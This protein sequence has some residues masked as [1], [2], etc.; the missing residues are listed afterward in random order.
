MKFITIFALLCAFGG[1][2]ANAAGSGKEHP[3][4]KVIN[5][6]EGLKAK[7]IAQGKDEEVAYTK[8]QYWCSTSIAE[9]KDAI[10]DEKEKIEELEDQL[11]GLN[12][13]KESLE[14]EIQT[15]EDQIGELEAAAKEAKE[16]RAAEAKLYDKANK[17]LESTIKAMDQCIAALKG[18]ESKTEAM[19]AQKHVRMVL[20][21]ISLKVTNS[22]R[23]VLEDFA[24]KPRPDQLAAG[25]L[26]AHVDKYDFKS[27]NVIELLK[28]LKLKFE[29]D[30]L[31]GT[32]AETN[33]VN[34]YE[35]AKEAR[36]NAIDAAKKA[37]G[38][39]E[40]KLASVEKDIAQAEKELKSTQDDLKADS[41]SLKETEEACNTK[42]EEWETRSETRTLELEAMDQ[43]IK[44]LAKSAGVRTEA[45]GNPIPPP[46]PVS[47]L[48]LSKDQTNDPKM[49]AVALL[50][51]A[52][53]DTHSRALERLA[54][55]V[56][57]HLSGPF[58]Q[59]NN[60][61]EKMIF[62]LMDEQKQEDEHKLW[63]DQ[64]IEKTETMKED[65]EEKIKDLKAE[66]KVET[67]AV[68]TLTEEIGEAEKMI[69]D[70]VAFMAEATEIRETGKKENALAIKD[71]KDA[72]KSVTNAI[73]VLEAFYKESGEIPKEPWEFIQKP[74]NLGKKPSTWDAGYTGVADPDQKNAGIISILEAVLSDFEKMEAETKSN[75]AQDQ[76]EYDKSMSANNIEKSGREQEVS[77]KTAE[78]KRRNDK[79]VSLNGQKKDTEAELEK[80]EQYLVDLKPAC[81]DGDSSYDDRKAA[82]A[83]E[84]EALKKA[85]VILEDAF[86]EKS[87]FLQ[88]RRH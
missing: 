68:Q 39:K 59:V 70:I 55:A 10:A 52:A 48:Q 40:K 76:E 21:L 33:S 22:Q 7:A 75:E 38:K 51:E 28:Q 35:V 49:K 69:S 61:I 4:A 42:K 58:D 2:S 3:I 5:L 65:K 43:A 17:D 80:T 56:A 13:E 46:S 23:K 84:I 37:K 47:F 53:Q 88:I 30:K 8:F 72:Q 27:E 82:R 31:A 29:D 60:M 81:V 79:I 20:S 50:K 77:M 25:D 19:L 67:A 11:A 73:A 12:K 87:K 78:K 15:L 32:K 44:I 1:T 66:I 26:D 54:V 34:A 6:L 16:N 74:V 83:K 45:P 62:R 57:A 71:S 18:A 41:K 64:E 9:L 63:C 86:K 85:Q 24:Q 14:K 36:D